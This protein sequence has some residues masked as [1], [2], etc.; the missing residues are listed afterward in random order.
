MAWSNDNA[1]VFYV[2]V[3]EAM[4]P[5]QLWRHRVGTEQAGDILV[6]EEED[7]RFYIG[8]GRTKDDRFV[9][10]GLDSKVTSEYR[11]LSADDPEGEFVVVEPRRQGVEYSVDHDRGNPAA[12]RAS[13]FLIVTNDGAED[14]RLMEAP[15]DVTGTGVLARGHPRPARGQARRGRPLRRPPGRLRAGGRGDPGPGRGSRLGRLDPGGPS[16]V[17]LDHLGWGQ[18]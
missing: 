11:A 3:D 9:L 5:Y 14:F 6:Y 1:T 13:R 4:R 18:S 8:V 17:A 12:G 2:R 10:L 16:R 7:E 15:D